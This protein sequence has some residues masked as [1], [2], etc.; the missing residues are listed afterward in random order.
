MVKFWLEVLKRAKRE[1]QIRIRHYEKH[2]MGTLA[3]SEKSKKLVI[4]RRIDDYGN[5]T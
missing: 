5:K 2:G 4:Q 3:M 1:N